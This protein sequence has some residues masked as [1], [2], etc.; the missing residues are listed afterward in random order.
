MFIQQ[1]GILLLVTTFLANFISSLPNL[2]LEHL[3]VQW[4]VI[5]YCVF[6]KKLFVVNQSLWRE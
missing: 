1:H 4:W 5:S 3:H 2:L 6:A